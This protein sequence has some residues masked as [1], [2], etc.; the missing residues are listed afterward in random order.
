MILTGKKYRCFGQFVKV[1]V[2]SLFRAFVNVLARSTSLSTKYVKAATLLCLFVLVSSSQVWATYNLTLLQSG[3]ETNK[4]SLIFIPSGFTSSQSNTFQTEVNNNMTRLWEVN[5]FSTNQQAF[6]VWRVDSDDGETIPV[7]DADGGN[8]SDAELNMLIGNLP[9]GLDRKFN[10]S[11]Q[12]RN[13]HIVLYDTATGNES[14]QDGVVDLFLDSDNYCTLAHELGH[15]S[16][17]RLDDE[18]TSDAIA[19]CTNSVYSTNVH[20]AD[21]AEKWIKYWDGDNWEDLITS[22]PYEGA[23]YCSQGLYRPEQYTIMGQYWKAGACRFD[24]LGQLAMD[25]GLAIR[26]GYAEANPPSLSSIIANGRTLSNGDVLS[27]S[28]RFE[29]TFTDASPIQKVEFYVAL[30]GEQPRSVDIEWPM[31][32][33]SP[34]TA[35]VAVDTSDYENGH[36]YLDIVAYDI[37]FNHAQKIGNLVIRDFYIDNGIN[38]GTNRIN[39]A[40]DMNYLGAFKLPSHA[41]IS[42]SGRERGMSYYPGGDPNDT[43]FNASSY[44]GSIFILGDARGGVMK[45]AEISI[46]TPVNSRTVGD[47]NTAT[48][49]QPFTDIT[50]GRQGGHNGREEQRDAEYFPEQSGEGN[51]IYW[52]LM[53][54]YEP[55]NDPIGYSDVDFS[56]SVKAHGLYGISCGSS[57]SPKLFGKF[58][59]HIPTA[60]A[61]THLNGRYLAVCQMENGGS[62]SAGPTMYAI[63]PWEYAQQPPPNGSEFPATLLLRYDSTSGGPDY[64]DYSAPNDF[65]NDGAWLEIGRKQ[66]VIFVGTSAARTWESHIYHYPTGPI[67]ECVQYGT[68]YTSGPPSPVILFYDAA[69]LADVAHGSIRPDQV[70]PYALVNLQ[71]YWW[72]DTEDGCGSTQQQYTGGVAYDR[73]RNLLYIEEDNNRYTDDIVHVFSLSDAMR[74]TDKTNPTNPS[75]LSKGPVSKTSISFSWDAS[76]DANGG[77]SYKIYR[78]GRPIGHVRDTTFTDENAEYYVAPYKYK[79]EA[80]DFVSNASELEFIVDPGD[81][82]NDPL[83]FFIPVGNTTGAN[84][85]GT[86]TEVSTLPEAYVGQNYSFTP[87]LKGGTAPYKWSVIN[88]SLGYGPNLNASTGVISGAVANNAGSPRMFQLQVED[89]NGNIYKRIVRW[90]CAMSSGCDKDYDGYDSNSGGCGGTDTDDQNFNVNPSKPTMTFPTNV[91]VSGNTLL[92]APTGTDDLS[93][94]MV[95]YGPSPGNYTG[96]VFVGSA[97][98]YNI[99]GLSGSSFAVT[100]FNVRG[101]ESGYWDPNDNTGPGPPSPPLDLQITGR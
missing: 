30:D 52:T 2:S 60:W 81:G 47:L 15:D 13:I 43:H 20:D 48:F 39:P 101:L 3:T 38:S 4:L 24:A 78:Q 32:P 75:N 23:R 11:R 79:I 5:W 22:S 46:A 37:H 90:K 17:G 70:Q 57:V 58:F 49:L 34:Y 62:W 26:L 98:E 69:V 19:P 18:Y 7:W 72:R 40:T 50:Y 74:T 33:S 27:G 85:A 10:A 99:S 44:P 63:A 89:A 96:S 68:G 95:Y 41:I 83:V 92:W 29:A 55:Q 42:W 53:D 87:I 35:Q 80:M 76:T 67:D 31:T 93:T 66:G 91:R 51:R 9:F 1:G 65:Y 84:Y 8:K 100:A 54:W 16:I 45:T 94:Y 25:H 73:T 36:Y 12:T 56:S 77:V 21:S 61:D 82:A 59:F 86:L 14:Q 71:Y 64:M 6:D 88:G 97:T 28:V